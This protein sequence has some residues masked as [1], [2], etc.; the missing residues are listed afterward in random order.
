MAKVL[1]Q[2]LLL[3]LQLSASQQLSALQL[4]QSLVYLGTIRLSPEEE[5]VSGIDVESE[6]AFVER[7]APSYKAG[8]DLAPDRF[9]GTFPS[10]VCSTCLY[11]ADQVLQAPCCDKIFC[12]PCLWH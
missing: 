2:P 7:A 10:V 6:G 8:E 1:Q 3:S 9:S 5:P 11:V 12:S 4:H